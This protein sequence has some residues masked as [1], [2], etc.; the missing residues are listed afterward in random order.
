MTVLRSF[1]CLK[2]ELSDMKQKKKKE[3][4]EKRWEREIK[5]RRS[6]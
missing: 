3:E 1:M 5:R 4:D 2:S 6:D